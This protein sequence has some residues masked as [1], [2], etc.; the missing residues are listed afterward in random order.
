MNRQSFPLSPSQSLSKAKHLFFDL[1]S[2]SPS[3]LITSVH[4]YG[5]MSQAS[6]STSLGAR[7]SINPNGVSAADVEAVK[8]LLA[9]VREGV[10]GVKAG[11]AGWKERY[12]GGPA[13][14]RS[15]GTA[16]FGEERRQQPVPLVYFCLLPSHHPQRW[17]LC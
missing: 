4:R 8:T 13:R 1:A 17:E 16:R 2:C 9:D 7:S 5:S 12:V 15:R 10:K 14:V 3:Y 6:T 11:V